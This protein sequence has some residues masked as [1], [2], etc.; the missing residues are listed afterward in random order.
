MVGALLLVLLAVV[1]LLL[2]TMMRLQDLAKLYESSAM[3]HP[4]GSPAVDPIEIVHLRRP[5][6]PPF[7]FLD[8]EDVSESIPTPLPAFVGPLV[9]RPGD[10][11]MVGLG[12]IDRVTTSLSQSGAVMVKISYRNTLPIPIRPDVEVVFYGFGM[13]YLGG[14]R[15]SWWHSALSPGRTAETY[16]HLKLE[17]D[18]I[19]HLAI[20]TPCSSKPQAEPIFGPYL[21]AGTWLFHGKDVAWTVECATPV[22]VLEEVQPLNDQDHV[23]VPFEE[24]IAE[25]H[26]TWGG[27]RFV[28]RQEAQTE[29]GAVT[30]ARSFGPESFDLS[31]VLVQLGDDQDKVGWVKREQVQGVP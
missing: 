21:E 15:V 6:E 8:H 9:G 17:G 20:V 31:W 16:H 29:E 4:L 30:L 7:S 19:R 10:M 2:D 25:F 24:L 26:R 12:G 14:I 5:E 3:I 28:G 13:H 22:K 18:S 11:I 23:L 27:W 1:Y